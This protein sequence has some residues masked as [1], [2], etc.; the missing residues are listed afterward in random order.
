MAFHLFQGRLFL[1]YD[2]ELQLFQNMNNLIHFTIHHE[3]DSQCFNDSD[4]K[5]NL[6]LLLFHVESLNILSQVL[7]L[8]FMLYFTTSHL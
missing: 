6:N 1:T 2:V 7:H 3:G 8:I 5:K 4:S